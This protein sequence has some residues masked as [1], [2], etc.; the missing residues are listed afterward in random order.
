M[1]KLLFALLLLPSTSAFSQWAASDYTAGKA[2]SCPTSGVDLSTVTAALANKVTSGA[3]VTLSTVTLSG[4]PISHENKTI[5][6]LKLITPTAKGQEFFCS[7]CVPPKNVVSTGTA[8]E[9]WADLTGGPF[10]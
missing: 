7:N 4:G 10:K 5:A 1:T 3:S 2:V 8:K 6:Q 9:N